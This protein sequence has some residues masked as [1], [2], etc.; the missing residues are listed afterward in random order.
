MSYMKNLLA[1]IYVDYMSGEFTLSEIEETY[2]VTKEFI[3]E[4]VDIMEE[5]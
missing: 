1:D 3:I 2:G 5:D 4:A